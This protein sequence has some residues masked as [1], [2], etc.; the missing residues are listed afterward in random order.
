MQQFLEQ[1]S[2]LLCEANDRTSDIE[3]R[4]QELTREKLRF[5]DLYQI[6]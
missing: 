6:K 2:R 4:K 5:V 1:S 3:E